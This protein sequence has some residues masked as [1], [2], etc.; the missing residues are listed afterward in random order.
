MIDKLTTIT[1]TLT[2]TPIRVKTGRFDWLIQPI[3]QLNN[4]VVT[5]PV[6]FDTPNKQDNPNLKIQIEWL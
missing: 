1:T 4:K 6:Q 5:N 2:T 3:Q